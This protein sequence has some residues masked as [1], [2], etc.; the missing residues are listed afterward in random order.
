MAYIR[1]G[2]H[3]P[4][5]W[6]PRYFECTAV[7]MAAHT[8]DARAPEPD[9]LTATRRDEADDAAGAQQILEEWSE[10]VPAT[11]LRGGLVPAIKRTLRYMLQSALNQRAFVNDYEEDLLTLEPW[12]QAEVAVEDAVRPLD[13]EMVLSALRGALG[14]IR[15][16]CR[17]YERV[18]GGA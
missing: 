10:S 5:Q 13:E 1:L 2:F 14:Q 15:K 16:D 8:E 9:Q 11:K 18:K 4:C 6:I 3:M 17:E 7:P 12:A